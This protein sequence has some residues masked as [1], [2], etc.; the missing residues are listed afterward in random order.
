MAADDSLVTGSGEQWSNKRIVFLALVIALI[1]Y[2]VFKLPPV[3]SGLLAQARDVVILLVLSVALAYFLLPLV[4]QLEK[5]PLPLRA[6]TRRSVAVL[7]AMLIVLA[8]AVG[9]VLLIAKPVAVELGNLAQITSGWAMGLPDAANRLVERHSDRLPVRW[10]MEIRRLAEAIK[11]MMTSGREGLEPLQ[12]RRNVLPAPPAGEQIDWSELLLRKLGEWSGALLTW[13]G[14]FMRN[15]MMHTTYLLAL[16]VVPVFAY[17]LLTDAERLRASAELLVPA[18]MRPQLRAMMAE[19]HQVLQGYV[20]SLLLV[21]AITG[22]A[23]AL[24]LLLAGVRVYLT[25]GIMAGVLNLILVVGP[26]I[27]GTLMG[28]VTLMQVSWQAMLVVLAAYLAVQV[29]VDRIVT[30]KLMGQYAHLHPI[31]II[32]ALLVGAK[33][34]G[35]IGLFIA[36]P[37]VAVARV[38]VEHHRAF[39]AGGDELEGLERILVGGQRTPAPDAAQPPADA[40][41]QEPA[42][43]NN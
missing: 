6:R 10:Q 17:Y 36:V 3:I 22:V 41:A 1:F 7:M 12:S 11:L 4:R 13:Y 9:L 16:L 19:A 31:T 14:N 32:V 34:L 27:A 8:L 30:P 5:I 43:G 24:I 40:P 23:T 35:A 42:D 15:V 18:E 37:A 33:F 28:M 21:S 20:R 2:V 38:A 26:V 39:S 29:L 25:F